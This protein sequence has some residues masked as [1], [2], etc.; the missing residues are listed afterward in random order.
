LGEVSQ[1]FK[2]FARG[3]TAHVGYDTHPELA[4]DSSGSFCTLDCDI[5]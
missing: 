5:R 4:E 3:D 2:I 1:E